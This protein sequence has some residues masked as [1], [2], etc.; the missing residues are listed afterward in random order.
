MAEIIKLPSRK[1][2][3]TV[4][5]NSIIDRVVEPEHRSDFRD[6]YMGDLIELLDAPAVQFNFTNTVDSDVKMVAKEFKRFALN[7]GSKYIPK[8]IELQIRVLELE[9]LFDFKNK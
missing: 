8:I 7:V 2:K 3:N 5:I 1:Y 9:R 6:R 4:F